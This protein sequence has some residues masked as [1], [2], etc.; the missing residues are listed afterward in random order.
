MR[1]APVLALLATL[2]CASPAL[3]QSGENIRHVKNVQFPDL[4]ERGEANLGTDLEFATITVPSPAA[5]VV[6]TPPSLAPDAA[7]KPVTKKSTK[8]KA[9]KKK[10]PTCKTRKQK[11][12]KACKRIAAKRKAA[13]RKRESRK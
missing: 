7:K 6:E 5:V 3:A 12:T 8:K 2:A 4:N 11:R 13:A 1:S 10:R 9:K